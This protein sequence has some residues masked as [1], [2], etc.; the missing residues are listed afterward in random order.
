MTGLHP[1]E[2]AMV[3]KRAEDVGLSG[4]LPH[5]IYVYSGVLKSG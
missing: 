5:T 3:T 2:V 4:E 1:G